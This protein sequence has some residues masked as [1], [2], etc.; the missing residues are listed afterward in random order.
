[1]GKYIDI[2]T[3]TGGGYLKDADAQFRS[4][5]A[6]RIGAAI[7]VCLLISSISLACVGAV[8]LVGPMFLHGENAA[9]AE[10]KIVSIGPGKDF[11]L[12]T[13][14]GRH[15]TFKCTVQCRASLGHM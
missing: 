9:H 10:G 11:V 14:S 7:F 8:V 12:E 3:R 2:P 13:A 5:I 6:P 1:M 15:F 4:S